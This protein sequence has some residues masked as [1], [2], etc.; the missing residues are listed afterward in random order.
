MVRDINPGSADAFN[1]NSVSM[2]VSNG[3]LYFYANDNVHGNEVWKLSPQAA[4][5][6]GFNVNTPAVT[7]TF[8]DPAIVN[9]TAATYTIQNLPERYN[10]KLWMTTRE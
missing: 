9:N 10:R 8:N 6:N 4:T 3:S 1:A 5:G 7:V 2:R